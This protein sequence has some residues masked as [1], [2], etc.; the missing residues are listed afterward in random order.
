VDGLR[1]FYGGRGIWYD[2]ARTRSLAEPG[3]TVGLMHTG[4]YYPD[5]LLSDGIVYHYPETRTLGKDANEVGATKS[6][7][8]LGVPVFV[9]VQRGQLRDV[10]MG[11][12]ED[13]AD[14]DKSFLV[15]FESAA[16]LT[17]GPPQ[18]WGPLS[19]EPFVAFDK[20]PKR[21]VELKARERDPRFGFRVKK[22]SGSACALIRI[23]VKGLLDAAHVI[24]ASAR[25]SFK[26]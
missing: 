8:R 2:P 22:R 17:S 14:A 7:G 23:Q 15:S 5:D 24:P 21:L 1:V 18:G 10:H 4:R 9:V 13:F 19:E 26:P 3:V 12:V 16:S 6:A 11:R 25:G 20:K